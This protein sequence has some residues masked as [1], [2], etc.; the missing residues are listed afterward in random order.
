MV[1][2]RSGSLEVPQGT[3]SWKYSGAKLPSPKPRPTLL[4]I[5]AA[6]ADHTLWHDQVDYLTAKSWNCLTFDLFGFGRSQPSKDFLESEPRPPVDYMQHIDLL[7]KEVLPAQ[8]KVILIGLSMGGGLA[9]DFALVHPELVVGLAV[10]AGN[11]SGFEHPNT[12]EENVLFEQKA[13][14]THAGDIE[15]LAKLNVR[16]WGDGPLQEPGRLSHTVA[17][18]LYTW[19]LDIAARE[20]SGEGGTALESVDLEPPASSRLR[21]MK[22]PVAVAFGTYDESE[23][24]AAMRHVGTTVDGA[25][26]KE[27]KT[28][29]MI[30]LEMPEEFNAWLSQWLE[31]NW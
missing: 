13:I 15:A 6:V 10:V 23:T 3:I 16:I 25:N 22:I 7:V 24:T 28:A 19:C 26:A 21:E 27:F 20:C 17:D 8:S 1:S 4:F 29:H 9:L 30:N 2:S 11:V 31:T 5:H 12:P 14:L 18:K